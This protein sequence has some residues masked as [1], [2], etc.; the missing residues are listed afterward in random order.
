MELK[1]IYIEATAKTPHIDLNPMTGELIFSGKSI[2]E[3]PA[4]LYESIVRMG[5]AIC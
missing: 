5:S 2:P 1:N 4:K 3:N